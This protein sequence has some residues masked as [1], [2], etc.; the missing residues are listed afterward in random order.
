MAEVVKQEVFVD[1]ILNMFGQL[2]VLRNVFRGF[3]GLV[4]VIVPHIVKMVLY[5]FL[6]FIIDWL[7]F[8]IVLHHTEKLR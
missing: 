7:A 6:E 1:S 5:L 3:H 2:L 4:L 8:I